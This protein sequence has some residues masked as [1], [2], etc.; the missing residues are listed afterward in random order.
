MTKGK[1]YPCLK[2][3]CSEGVHASAAAAY[4]CS[5]SYFSHKAELAITLEDIQNNGVIIDCIKKSKRTG[6]WEITYWDV[7]DNYQTTGWHETMLE[8]VKMLEKTL[9]GRKGGE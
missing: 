9:K 7:R 4:L 6:Q 5:A 1:R 3:G 8:A 2:L